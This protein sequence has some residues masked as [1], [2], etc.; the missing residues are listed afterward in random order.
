MNLH[1]KERA[2]RR[3]RERRSKW[4]VLC[5]TIS[6][7]FLDFSGHELSSVT[8]FDGFSKL[9][10]REVDAASIGIGRMFFGEFLRAQSSADGTKIVNCA[11]DFVFYVGIMMLLDIPEERSGDLDLRWGEPKDCRFSLFAFIKPLTAAR[12]G[13][14]YGLMWI[15]KVRLLACSGFRGLKRERK[16]FIL[17]KHSICQN[18]RHREASIIGCV[19]MKFVYH[20]S[21]KNISENREGEVRDVNTK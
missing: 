14:V 6:K 9:M 21:V 11:I 3:L 5:G 2:R 1:N 12:M 15:G 4:N 13:L 18:Q 8:S 16:V 10:H 19:L 7:T 17:S 20:R